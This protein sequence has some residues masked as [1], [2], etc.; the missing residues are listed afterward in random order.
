MPTSSRTLAVP[1]ILPPKPASPSPNPSP[2]VSPVPG[3]RTPPKRKDMAP[4]ID[5][6]PLVV[7]KKGEGWEESLRVVL[8]RWVEEA[9]R[10]A[11]ESQSDAGETTN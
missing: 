7:A 1:L 11:R 2:S 5:F 3:M 6:D 9:A 10:E 8:E 4:R